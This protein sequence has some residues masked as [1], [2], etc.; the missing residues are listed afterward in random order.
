FNKENFNSYIQGG[1]GVTLF[2]FMFYSG[3]GISYS[4]YFIDMRVPKLGI[5]PTY[6]TIGIKL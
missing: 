5:Y 4:R 1:I 2:G 3:I 6:L